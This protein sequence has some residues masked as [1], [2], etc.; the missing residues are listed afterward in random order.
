MRNE[1]LNAIK[2]KLKK[3]LPTY[4]VNLFELVWGLRFFDIITKVVPKSC[5]S[6]GE[7]FLTI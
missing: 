3:G 4:F 6:V 2:V 1:N 7:A 5:S